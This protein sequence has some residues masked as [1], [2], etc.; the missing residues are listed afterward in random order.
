MVQFCEQNFPIWRTRMDDDQSL[1]RF[2]V[3]GSPSNYTCVS[4][5][6]VH[7]LLNVNFILLDN[8]LTII[9]IMYKTFEYVL[10]TNGCNK[11]THK[12]TCPAGSA[13]LTNRM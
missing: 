10:N 3:P 4:R 11:E 5:I 8:I 9:I 2:N 1:L 6:S 13:A 12:S 7:I